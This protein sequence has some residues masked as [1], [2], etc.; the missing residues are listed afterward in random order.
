MVITEE[1]GKV[2]TRKKMFFQVLF[3]SHFLTSW[4]KQVTSLSLESRYVAETQRDEQIKYKER[5]KKK[6]IFKRAGNNKIENRKIE[7]NV[8]FLNMDANFQ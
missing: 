8:S 2:K 1:K 6:I 7:K 4:L 5:R 3:E